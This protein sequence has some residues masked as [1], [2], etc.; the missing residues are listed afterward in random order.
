MRPSH[1]TVMSFVFHIFISSRCLCYL[2]LPKYTLIKFFFLS[3]N[4][5][6]SFCSPLSLL[7][8]GII[9][10]IG[11]QKKS[12][13]VLHSMAFQM[14]FFWENENWISRILLLNR[15]NMGFVV[16]VCVCVHLFIK[17]S[18]IKNFNKKFHWN[19]TQ[20]TMI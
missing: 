20:F 10:V 18:R 6:F 19:I 12:S 1:G 17:R 7:T 3:F 15:V 5:S 13:F 9:T 11:W 16:W 8:H 14:L 2:H 4:S